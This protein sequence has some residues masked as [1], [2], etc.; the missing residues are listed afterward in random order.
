MRTRCARRTAAFDVHEVMAVLEAIEA[1]SGRLGPPPAPKIDVLVL[2]CVSSLE[3]KDRVFDYNACVHAAGLLKAELNA[4]ETSNSNYI[5][6]G[7]AAVDWLRLHSG[8]S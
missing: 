4:P 3:E 2:D 7:G 1:N 5:T 6:I 8:S